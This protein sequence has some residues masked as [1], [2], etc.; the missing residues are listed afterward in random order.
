MVIMATSERTTATL[1]VKVIIATMMI[2]IIIITSLTIMVTIKHLKTKKMILILR[3]IRFN[4]NHLSSTIIATTISTITNIN[5]IT[6]T[7]N[8]AII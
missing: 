8:F 6:A 3:Q 1:I 4:G 7:I 2:T 5:A